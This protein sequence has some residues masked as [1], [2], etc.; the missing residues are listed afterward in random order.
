M[1]ELF[2]KIVDVNYNW[3]VNKKTVGFLII[4]GRIEVN[5]LA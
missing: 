5:K 3:I 4:S 2:P 1:M